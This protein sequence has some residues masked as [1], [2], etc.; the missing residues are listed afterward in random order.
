[1]FNRHRISTLT[2][3]GLALLAS[4]AQAR[5]L[6]VASWGGA[7]QD[8]QREIFFKPYTQASGNKVVD[9]S[10]EGGIG[11]LRTRAESD[12]GGWDLVQVEGEDLV[13]AGEDAA[14]VPGDA[15]GEERV[16]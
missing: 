4:G 7:Y 12:D 14:G 6:T 9:D 15:F 3:C 5:D 13:L 8:V 1:M 11:L 2:L 16:A 10:W